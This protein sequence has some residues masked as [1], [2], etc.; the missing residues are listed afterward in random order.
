MVPVLGFTCGSSSNRLTSAP[1]RGGPRGKGGDSDHSISLHI[2][3][4]SRIPRLRADRRF[5]CVMMQS[6]V[7]QPPS[8]RRPAPL[9]VIRPRRRQTRGRLRDS[10][11]RN[12]HHSS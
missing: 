8:L 3:E 11:V 5:T 7:D 6:P 12:E 4:R 10:L 9:V 1:A 2:L